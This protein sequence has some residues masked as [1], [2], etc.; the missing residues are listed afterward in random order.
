MRRFALILP[1]LALACA[2]PAA[3]AETRT[4]GGSVSGPNGNSAAYGG[5]TNCSGGSCGT[6]GSA[7]GPAGNTA[8]RT[9]NT[10]CSGGSCTSTGTATGPN[11]QSINRS[12]GR[13]VTR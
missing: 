10:A 6:T 11:G 8:T 4:R 5:T 9:G 1:V 13:T 3:Q 7:T 12:G 2:I